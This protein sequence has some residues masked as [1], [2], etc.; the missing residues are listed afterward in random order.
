MRSPRALKVLTYPD[1]WLLKPTVEVTEGQFFTAEMMV[2][3]QDLRLT[4]E[5]EKG[6]GIAAPQVGDDYLRLGGPVRLFLADGRC[7]GRTEPL[8]F[9]NPEILRYS[10]ASASMV[11]GCLSCPGAQ[12]EVVRPASVVCRARDINFDVFDIE[13]E[14]LLARVIQHEYEHLIG[15]LIVA[16]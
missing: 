8:V 14:G 15:K 9:F 16:R 11:E 7:F 2:F 3:V 12:V 5:T 4:M 6:I 1:P 13:A 10:A